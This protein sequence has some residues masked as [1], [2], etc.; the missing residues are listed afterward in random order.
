MRTGHERLECVRSPALSG[1]SGQ[2][3][4]LGGCVHTGNLLASERLGDAPSVRAVIHR[5]AARVSSTASPYSASFLVPTPLT[6]PSAPTDE[7]L[8]STMPTRVASE[9]TM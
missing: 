5:A 7:G 1:S 8:A 4:H 3:Q 6:P 9:N 2:I